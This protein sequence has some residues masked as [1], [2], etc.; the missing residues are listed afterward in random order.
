MQRVR[1]HR[2]NG[3]KA[4]GHKVGAH[5]ERD[6][7]KNGHSG[8]R[9][10]HRAN[11]RGCAR[12]R[13]LAQAERE[14][15]AAPLAGHVLAL[16]APDELDGAQLV[17]PQA[18]AVHGRHDVGVLRQAPL[19][20][21]AE[22]GQQVADEF[23][24]VRQGAQRNG[25]QVLVHGALQRFGEVGVRDVALVAGPKPG[26][27]HAGQRHFDEGRHEAGHPN[28]HDDVDNLAESKTQCY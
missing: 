26:G 23:D 1:G 14:P 16:V 4:V 28:E 3:Q 15:R 11:G 21:A 7:R 10:G 25:A 5:A 27:V 17:V 6:Q 19:G 20:V 12:K 24:G 13:Q 2:I 18:V 8:G 9:R 22:H